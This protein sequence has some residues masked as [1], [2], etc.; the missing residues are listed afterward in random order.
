M[1]FLKS[2]KLV[3]LVCILYVLLEWLFFV[4]K[5]SVLSNLNALE[6]I[7][8]LFLSWLAFFTV[9]LLIH[10]VFYFF[11]VLVSRISHFKKLP[12]YIELTV[13]CLVLAVALFLLL[14][15]FTYTLLGIASFS[16]EGLGR[17]FYLLLFATLLVFCFRRIIAFTTILEQRLVAISVSLLGC[18]V[19]LFSLGLLYVSQTDPVLSE[20]PQRK[21]VTAEP[22]T[23]VLFLFAD[24]V[25]SS[26]MSLY[27]YDRETTPFLDSIKNEL[28][29]FENHFTNAATSTASIGALLSGKYPATTKLIYRP[30]LFDGRD[31]YEHF[32]S[33]LKRH[34]YTNADF[35]LR[36][37]ID[38]ADLNMQGGFDEANGRQLVSELEKGFLQE[39]Y[40]DEYVFAVVV[41]ERASG[42]VKHLLGI[43]KMHNPFDIVTTRGG[44][45]N[46][47][48]DRKRIDDLKDFIRRANAPFFA[49]VHLLGT[50]GPLFF[51]EKHHFSNGVQ[52]RRWSI[53]HYDDAVLQ[54]DRYIEEVVAFLKAEGLYENTLLVVNA[55]HGYRWGVSTPLPLAFRFPGQQYTGVKT[56]NTQRIDI[57][58]TVLEYL[59]I[60]P[61]GWMEG[62]SLLSETNRLGAPIY[63]VS[64]AP[65]STKN[66]WFFVPSPQPPFYTLG[67]ISAIYCDRIYH[68]DI[69]KPLHLVEEKIRGYTGRCSE[70]DYPSSEE[71]YADLLDHLKGRGYDTHTLQQ[72]AGE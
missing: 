16:F 53:D 5:P 50:H 39:Y 40:P 30:D 41:Y 72:R 33:V 49:H 69:N 52:N 42:R 3:G 4:T 14:D 8:A 29:I 68:L 61:P 28:L 54:Y 67:V 17:Y 24:G 71:I 64:P 63:V 12:V 2:T 32:P 26:R 37:Y 23:N 22:T 15:N 47:S 34:D 21:S 6:K 66:G 45:E 36:Y 38:P 70:T 65:R 18:L 51:S 7:S 19:L 55:D 10:L 11:A 57:P 13:P 46:V 9:A 20:L 35:S 62:R 31:S 59:D 43:E 56:F 25:D 1:K 44:A 27:G 58:Y 60:A 48:M